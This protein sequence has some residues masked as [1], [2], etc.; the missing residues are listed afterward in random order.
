VAK[1]TILDFHNYKYLDCGPLGNDADERRNWVVPWFRRLVADFIQQRPW[2]WP[3]SHHVEFV[4][5][6]VAQG[7]I[8][9]KYFSLYYQLLYRLLHIHH[10]PW[11]V[12]GTIGQIVADV[13]SGLRLAAAQENS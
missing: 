1:H 5:D 3:K 8:S 9:Y 7:Q 10:H 4:V 11:T 2:L 13:S 12:A 6:K